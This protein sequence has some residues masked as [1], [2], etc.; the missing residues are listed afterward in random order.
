MITAISFSVFSSKHS[1]IS[2]ADE[3]GFLGIGVANPSSTFDSSIPEFAQ[4]N[5]CL[6]S[7]TMKLGPTATIS[8]DS[9]KIASTSFGSFLHSFAIF[10]VSSLGS[11]SSIFM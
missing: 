5:P 1:L 7:V 9:C 3:S 11:S 10:I 2:F 6:V 4:T 8:F